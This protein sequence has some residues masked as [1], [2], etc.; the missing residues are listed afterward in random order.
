MKKTKN[1]KNL[2]NTS[3]QK[4]KVRKKTSQKVLS[5]ASHLRTTTKKLVDDVFLKVVGMKVLARAQEMTKTLRKEQKPKG[6]GR[7]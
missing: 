6:K 7:T 3:T 4:S 5:A 1:T 2:R